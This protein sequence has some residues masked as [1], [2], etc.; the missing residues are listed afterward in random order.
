MMGIAIL[1]IPDKEKVSRLIRMFEALEAMIS[2]MIGIVMKISPFG[3][4]FL[5]G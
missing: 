1:L 5:D 2:S 4:I 3:N